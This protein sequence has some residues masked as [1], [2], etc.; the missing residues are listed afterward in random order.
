MPYDC[1][2]LMIEKVAANLLGNLQSAKRAVKC[3]GYK[4]Q[5][6]RRKKDPI[7]KAQERTEEKDTR[8]LLGERLGNCNCSWFLVFRISFFV[9][10]C[11]FFVLVYCKFLISYL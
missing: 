3:T 2:E 4:A 8:K 9:S 11:W 5:G 7:K 10:G 1:I 6:T